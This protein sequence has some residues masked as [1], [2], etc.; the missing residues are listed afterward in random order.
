MKDYSERIKNIT[1]RAKKNNRYTDDLLIGESCYLFSLIYLIQSFR[2][3][4]ITKD[5]LSFQQKKLEQQLLSYYQHREIYEIH[6]KI[7]NRYSTIL[8][9]AEKN[10]CSV[11]KKIARVFDGRET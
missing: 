6:I 1:D 3:K 2:I 8:S 5:E 11:C 10:G 9:E 4:L 7:Q